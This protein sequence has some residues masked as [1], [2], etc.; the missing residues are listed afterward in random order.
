MHPPRPHR[1]VRRSASAVT[2]L[3]VILALLGAVG[4]APGAD[5][6]SATTGSADALPDPLRDLAA[7]ADPP[8]SVR[9]RMRWWWAT[10]YVD[11]EFVDELDAMAAAG[12]GGVEIAYNSNGWATAEQRAALRTVLSRASQLGL[13]VDMTM[14]ASWPVTSPAVRGQNGHLGMQE[15]TYAKT[16]VVGPSTFSGAAPGSGGTLVAVTAARVATPG[17]PVP[18]GAAGPN[19]T[20]T[21]PTTAPVAS[22]VLDPASLVDLTH[23]IDDAGRLTW[24]VPEGHWQVFGLR[25]RTTAEAVMDHFS[26][27]SADAITGYIDANML[28]D[29]AAL[30]PG[31]GGAFFEDSLEL[32]AV[33]MWT[34][35]FAEEF[36]ARRGY[37]V[38]PYLPLLFVQGAHHYPVWEEMPDPDYDLPGGAGDRIRHD[39][40][41]TL[42]DLYVD[43]HLAVFHEWAQT[44]G[45]R[46]RTQAAFG[47]AL[48]VTRSARELAEM[49]AL[50]DDESLNAGDPA[51]MADSNWRFALDHYRSVM[52]GVHQ[53]GGSEAFSELGAMFWRSWQAGLADYKALMDKQWVTGI[54]TPIIHGFAY[55]P[56][57]TAFPGRDQFLGGLVSDSWNHRHWPQWSMWGPL[58]DY[59]A[60]GSL[61]LQQGRPQ[62]DVAVYRDGFVTSAATFAALGT[63]AVNH[64]VLPAVP[65]STTANADQREADDVAG[66]KPT[67]FFDAEALERTGYT[68]EYLDPQGLLEPAAAG[69]GV[70]FPDG[71]AY[72][73]LVVDERALPGDAA[74]ALAAEAAKGLGVVFVGDLPDAGTGFTDADAEDQQVREAVARMMVLPRVAR[75]ATQ[76]DVGDA[77][78][79]I[80]VQ[81]AARLDA[82]AHDPVDGLLQEVGLAEA[83][84]PVYTSFR[85]GDGADYVLLWNAGGEA[86]TFD[87][88]LETAGAGSVLDLWSGD[89][90]PL[91]RYHV[92]DGRV[93]VPLTMQP[94]ETVVLGFDRDAPVPLHVVD[95]DVEE[96]VVEAGV[97]E[98]RDSR[99]GSRSVTLSDGSRVAVDVPE[100]PGP[101]SPSTWDLHVAAV[102]PG[103]TTEQDLS[104]LLLQ[105]WRDIPQIRRASG[106]GTYTAT[107]DV[108][109]D[110]LAEGRG[111]HLA[112]GVVE[113]AM[114]LFVNGQRVTPATSV[115]RP[116]ADRPVVTADQR[117]DITDLLVPGSNELRVV[118]T[119]TLKNTI[120]GMW[121]S[122]QVGPLLGGVQPATQPYGLLGPV[123]LVPYSSESVGAG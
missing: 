70:L 49:G 85:R 73:A 9:P 122:G 98:L 62:V 108:P 80:G 107:V 101:L 7:F 67:P 1:S 113:G 116:S 88:S 53:G 20:P 71:P 34:W 81:P 94:G 111:V 15:L 86:V 6:A 37:D 39:Y 48:D 12:F 102:G 82:P 105:D 51:T 72:R 104:L 83:G 52:G 24:E 79:E 60:R 2:A 23:L 5:L 21:G 109:A 68:L 120:V 91:G 75:A 76:A 118:V 30:L 123:E 93:V 47:A 115:D 119:T 16:D 63:D 27:A 110:W 19:L 89:I 8:A 32:D 18:V 95:G 114:Q 92:A 87:A 59:W 4:P 26:A 55:D 84:V 14:G 46:F 56:P 58:N 35:R 50:A 31:T 13:S 54:T 43:E 11:Q 90:R 96:V 22:T 38:T 10:P 112:P 103:G 40:Y 57:G 42:T 33:L 64:Q 97:L 28:G 25:Q 41:Q 36:A 66:V 29:S 121:Q 3:V 65:G 78:A 17:Q 74:E 44:H 77:L 100:L 69:D 99:P 45:M 106:T 117:H 61:V